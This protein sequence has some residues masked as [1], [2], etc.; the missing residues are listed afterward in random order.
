M[1]ASV[2]LLSV[3][4]ALGTAV[5]LSSA[6]GVISN[7][8]SEPLPAA[9]FRAA[10]V[11]G[12]PVETLTP[13][14]SEHRRTQKNVASVYNV[15]VPQ[16]VTRRKVVQDVHHSFVAKPYTVLKPYTVE[17]PVPVYQPYPVY[18]HEVE[19]KNPLQLVRHHQHT[20]QVHHFP[21]VKTAD[22][23]HHS[24]QPQVVPVFEI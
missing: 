15:A 20:Q 4:C 9:V 14:I 16:P 17:H 21:L 19:V 7:D 6:G 1:F 5:P 18:H 8:P 10:S 24:V 22:V 11:A 2:M 12:R 13:L 23:V 3:A